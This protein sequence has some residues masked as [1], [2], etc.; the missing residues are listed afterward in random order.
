MSV[1]NNKTSLDN[2]DNKDTKNNE[3]VDTI[4]KPIRG[5]VIVYVQEILYR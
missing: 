5:R 4:R 1:W 2:K 3:R